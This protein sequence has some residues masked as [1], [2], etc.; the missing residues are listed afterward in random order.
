MPLWIKTISPRRILFNRADFFEAHE[1]WEDIWRATRRCGKRFL[2]RTQSRSPGPSTDHSTGNLKGAQSLLKR[3]CKIW[4]AVR[5]FFGGVRI[6]S[7]AA[8]RW[9]QWQTALAKES[10]VPHLPRLGCTKIVMPSLLGRPEWAAV[11]PAPARRE[12]W[13]C[14]A[15][16][17]AR[18]S[19]RCR[20]YVQDKR[21]QIPL[22][23]SLLRNCDRQHTV[24]DAF[25]IAV[26]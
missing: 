11:R 12:R 1:T 24:Q 2:A 26:S 17:Y 3:G 13:A 8:R 22:L 20:P 15:C 23:P 9:A 14:S 6:Y 18:L 7:Y 25:A 4:R 10:P 19:C 16:T 21:R 5:K